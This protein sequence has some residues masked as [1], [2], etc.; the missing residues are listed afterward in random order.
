MYARVDSTVGVADAI[1]DLT[2]AFL[3]ARTILRLHRTLEFITLL[4]SDLLDA[5]P[6]KSGHSIVSDAY[7]K[8]LSNHHAWLVRKAASASFYAL[9]NRA[10]LVDAISADVMGTESEGSKKG[11]K[12]TIEVSPELKAAVTTVL[13]TLRNTHAAVEKLYTDNKLH[14]LP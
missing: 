2:C 10:G 11:K 3:T 9:P 5:A 1:E 8:T 4:I 7:G 6:D 14:E 13:D 12:D